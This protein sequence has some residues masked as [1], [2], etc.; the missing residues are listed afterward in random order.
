M[1][2]KRVVVLGGLTLVASGVTLWIIWPLMFWSSPDAPLELGARSMSALRRPL[3]GS[4]W[5]VNNLA[6]QKDIKE[7]GRLIAYGVGLNQFSDREPKLHFSDIFGLNRGDGMAEALTLL[8]SIKHGDK[9]PLASISNVRWGM[10]RVAYWDACNE[11]HALSIRSVYESAIESQSDDLRERLLLAVTIDDFM[12]VFSANGPIGGIDSEFHHRSYLAHWM[13]AQLINILRAKPGISETWATWLSE[14][15][16]SLAIQFTVAS[17]I[18][19]GVLKPEDEGATPESQAKVSALDASAV[20]M[21]EFSH[22]R[23]DETLLKKYELPP[24]VK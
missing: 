12:K 9:A 20:Q 1:N 16:R 2:K 23:I 11:F 6:R 7:Q 14:C 3:I 4:G 19:H 5:Y 13:H 22:Y 8:W 17:L 10:P 21:S 15:P 18:L 24:F